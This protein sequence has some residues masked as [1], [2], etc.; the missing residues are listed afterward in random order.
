MS[1]DHDTS[2]KIGGISR[3]DL[4]YLGGLT[5]GALAV[6]TILA[7]VNRYPATPVPSDRYD[8]DVLVVGSG[9]AG[10]FAAVEASKLGQ[11]VV[12][13]DKGSVGWSG[14]SPWA[15]DSRPFDPELYDRKEWLDNLSTALLDAHRRGSTP[16][17]IRYSRCD[18]TVPIRLGDEWRVRP[19]DALLSR[20]RE[21]TGNDRVE[22]EYR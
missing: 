3:R 18:A 13:V 8:A 12:L 9:F 20:L 11:R 10:V 4:F 6:P 5:A 7:N 15:S 19:T 2:P 1:D 17:C 14:M 22:V 16:V 21:L